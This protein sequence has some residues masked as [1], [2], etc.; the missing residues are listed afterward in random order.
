MNATSPS[1]MTRGAHLAE[2]IAARARELDELRAFR[3]REI[4]RLYQAGFDL[5]EVA[6]C[7]GVNRSRVAQILRNADVPR[8]P[9]GRRRTP[10]ARAETPRCEF[11]NGTDRCQR[12][13]ATGDDYCPSHRRAVSDMVAA[14]RDSLSA[15]TRPQEE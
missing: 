12:F 15:F 8:R 2:T 14:A 13:A 7:H 6:G 1:I 9:R 10:D 5:D 4:V 11:V 3:D